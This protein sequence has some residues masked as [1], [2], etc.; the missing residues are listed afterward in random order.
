MVARKTAKQYLD[1]V[2]KLPL[3]PTLVTELLA[4]F[5]DPDKDVSRVVELISYEPSLTVEILRNCN[6]VH[7]SGQQPPSDIFE[8]VARMGFYEVYCLVVAMFGSTVRSIQGADKGVN[9]HELWRHSVAVAVCASLIA[10]KAGE[11]RAVAFTAGL[12]HDMGKL[13]LASVERERYAQLFQTARTQGIIFNRAE[14]SALETN[15]AELGGELMHRWNLPPDIVA[16]VRHHHNF[17]SAQ[18]VARLTAVVQMADFIAHQVCG[19]DLAN[20]DLFPISTAA[21]DQL[22]LNPDDIARLVD[23]AHLEMERVKQMLQM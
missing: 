19:E 3:A 12:L 16:A 20:T 9:I 22:R 2:A 5:R 13:V 15:H 6:S 17:E 8:A 21:V 18:D 11:E 23:T 4:V 10:E 1:S 7:F 14:E